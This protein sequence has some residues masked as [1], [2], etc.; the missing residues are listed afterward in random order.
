MADIIYNKVLEWEGDS[1]QV[2]ASFT[3]KTRKEILKGRERI[4]YGRILF[5]TGDFDDYWDLVQTRNDIIDRNKAKISQ[6]SIDGAGGAAGGGYWFGE[7]PIAGNAL[8]TVPDELVYSGDLVLSLEIYMGGTLINTISVY[9]EKPFRLGTSG[10]R[11]ITFET[12]LIGNVTK[13]HQMDFGASIKEI[14]FKTETGID[15]GESVVK[16]GG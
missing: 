9:H 5:E 12:K 3:I 8:E 15:L 16:E 6:G 10:K 4:A 14:M 2:L 7:V 11:N 13:V 1:S